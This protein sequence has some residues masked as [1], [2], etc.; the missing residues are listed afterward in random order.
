MP[1]RGFRGWVFAMQRAYTLTIATGDLSLNI[2]E[3]VGVAS[4]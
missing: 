4:R 2:F 1:S 3:T